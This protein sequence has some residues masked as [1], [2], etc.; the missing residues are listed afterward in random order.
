MLAGTQVLALATLRDATATYHQLLQM[1]VTDSYFVRLWMSCSTR[2]TLSDGE[3]T[4]RQLISRSC[5]TCALDEVSSKFELNTH[6][7]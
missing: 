4:K 6:A 7:F 3:D 2:S 5:S 1:Y